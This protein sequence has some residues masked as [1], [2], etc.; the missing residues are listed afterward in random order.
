M[1][2]Q[3]IF[4]INYFDGIDVQRIKVLMAV[5]TDII[6]KHRPQELH[7]LF[8]SPGGQVAAGITF[9]NFLRSLPVKVVMHNTGQI[10][11]IANVVFLA[12]EERYATHCSSFLFHGIAAQFPPNVPLTISQLRERE[13]SMKTDENKIARIITERTNL[14]DEE[15]RSLFREGQSKNPDFA[16]EMDIIHDIR[17]ASIPDG[18]PIISVNIN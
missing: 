17:D 10:D 12:G 9:Y 5:C 13:S 8:S 1:P 7:F 11:S 15:I 14:Q 3:P 6:T 4:Y 2:N 18:A 16:K